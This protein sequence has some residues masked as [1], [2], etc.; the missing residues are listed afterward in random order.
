M[1]I[2]AA[3]PITGGGAVDEPEHDADRDQRQD[4]DERWLFM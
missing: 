3:R 4:A 2:T 1:S